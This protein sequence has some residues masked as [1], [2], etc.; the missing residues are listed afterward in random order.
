MVSV[1]ASST[2]ITP[3]TIRV[4][5]VPLDLGQSRRGVDMG[6]SAVRCAGLEYK[7]EQLGHTVEDSGNVPVAMPEQKNPGKPEAKY[8]AKPRKVS[9]AVDEY[10][11]HQAFGRIARRLTCICCG[12]TSSI[13]PSS[14]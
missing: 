4:I 2:T 1:P 14:P 6:P 11:I 8:L 5:G 12:W 9:T 3:K 13:S 10:G 7:L